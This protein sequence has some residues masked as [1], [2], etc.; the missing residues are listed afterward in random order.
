[1]CCSLTNLRISPGAGKVTHKKPTPS[2]ARQTI[3]L[4]TLSAV[5]P[6]T[7][8]KPKTK[9]PANMLR[10]KPKPSADKPTASAKVMPANCTKESKKPDCIKLKPKV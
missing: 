6:M 8:A 4:K 5:A 7:L 10:F 9:R 3:R 2:R 1:M